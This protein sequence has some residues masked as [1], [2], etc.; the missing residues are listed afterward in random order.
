[1]RFLFMGDASNLHNTLARELRRQ[2][3]EAVVVSGGSAWMDTGRDI[4]LRRK[5]GKWGGACYLARL[6]TLLPRMRGYDV[7]EIAGQVFL[8]LRPE[9]IKWVFDYLKRH[10]KHVIL[11]ALAT[12][13]N[14]YKAC[15]DGHTFR[16]SD[17]MIGDKPSPYVNSDEYRAQQQDNWDAPAMRDLSQHITTQVDGVAACLWEYYVTYRPLVERTVHTGIPIDTDALTMRPL[18]AEPEKL[19]FFLGLQRDRMVVKGTDRLFEAAKR[20]VDRYPEQCELKVV[21]NV[22]YDEYVRLMRDSHV[23]LDQLYSYTPATNALLGMAQG[24]VAVSGAEPECYDMIGECD[25]CPIINVSPL[26]EG[27]ID[28]K[29]EWLVAQKSHLPDLARASRDF[30]VKHNAASIVAQKHLELAS[31][32]KGDGI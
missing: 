24:L 17:Y 28:A 27:D 19:K 23:I 26:I 30:V 4:T 22:P 8:S 32:L 3:H 14:Y 9:K 31:S 2:G 25:N 20:V 11:S 18:E 6:L 12:D 29:L 13:H 21:E 5:P 1:M 7:V 15:H 10:N 16:Y